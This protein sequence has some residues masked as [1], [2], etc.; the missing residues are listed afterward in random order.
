MA[1]VGEREPAGLRRIFPVRLN[2]H[3]NET[4]FQE[5]ALC[6]NVLEFVISIIFSVQSSLV[7]L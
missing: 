5:G 3:S 6:G 7:I 1:N 4:N 2:H